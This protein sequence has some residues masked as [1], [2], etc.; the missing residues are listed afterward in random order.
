MSQ[1]WSRSEWIY[2]SFLLLLLLWD[3]F[4][5]PL[6]TEEESEVNYARE[7]GWGWG[8]IA[9]SFGTQSDVGRMTSRWY[10]YDDIDDVAPFVFCP[11]RHRGRVL[12]LQIIFHPLRRFSVK[13]NQAQKISGKVKDRMY[14]CGWD[15]SFT[16][17][18]LKR[19]RKSL[20]QFR[21]YSGFIIK[22]MYNVAERIKSTLKNNLNLRFSTNKFRVKNNKRRSRKKKI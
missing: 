10:I 19:P 17:I 20:S 12:C 9:T 14:V 4:I 18:A 16:E 2:I 1:N 22:G 6:C 13:N 7:V 11:S 21:F 5:C 15:S 3:I 8:Q